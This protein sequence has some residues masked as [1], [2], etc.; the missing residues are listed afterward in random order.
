M[1]ADICGGDEPALPGSSLVKE[2]VDGRDY[3]LE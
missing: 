3:N 1:A 2:C